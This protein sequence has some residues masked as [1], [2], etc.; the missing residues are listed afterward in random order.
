MTVHSELSDWLDNLI[1][2]RIA[3][4][5]RVVAALRAAGAD[6]ALLVGPLGERRGDAF[7]DL[8]LLIVTGHGYA[9]IDMIGLFGRQLL[10]QIAAQP[11]APKGGSHIGVCL[12]VADVVLWL[13][14]VQWP[15]ATAAIPADSL[16]LYAHLDLPY[17]P[18]SYRRL[19][20]HHPHP[21]AAIHP[22]TAATELRRI[23]DAAK[24]LARGNPRHIADQIPQAAGLPLHQIRPLL[25]QRL[26]EIDQPSL[27]RAIAGTA[28]LV[29]LAD[30][31]RTARPARTIRIPATRDRKS[32]T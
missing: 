31:T 20:D 5:A 29:D 12:D 11:G 2:G 13:D 26:A 21:A 32:N 14:L 19:L 16:I 10:A 30:M 3:A 28:A 24:H 15:T 17:S 22:P 7:S 1:A 23:A 6:A 25:H 4:G 9:S 27:V 8:D 18:L